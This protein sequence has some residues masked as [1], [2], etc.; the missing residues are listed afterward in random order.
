MPTEQW[1]VIPGGSVPY[2]IAVPYAD[3][4]HRILHSRRLA[5]YLYVI[6][7]DGYASDLDHLLWVIRGRVTEIERW[8]K[9]IKEDSDG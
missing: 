7:S 5:P 9:Q 3:A 4:R 1:K 2:E 6:L 8:A